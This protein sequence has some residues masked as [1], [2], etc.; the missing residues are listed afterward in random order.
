M[1]QEKSGKTQFGKISYEYA[2]GALKASRFAPLGEDGFARIKGAG[3]S[4]AV[5][6]ISE[7]GYPP[8]AEGFSPADSIDKLTEQL[9]DFIKAH[10]PD[11]VLTGAL[12]FE[13][14]A[15]NLKIYLK[16]ARSSQNT[17]G[18]GAE[19]SGFSL[20]SGAFDKE[21][22]KI[23]GESGDFSLLGKDLETALS[24]AAEI[25][26]PSFLSCKID[27]AFFSR[28][29][30]VAKKA[31]ETSLQKLLISYGA[32]R[33]SLTSLRLN[34]LGRDEK[35]HFYAFFPISG[36]SN[37]DEDSYESSES[38]VSAKSDGYDKIIAKYGKEFE[39]ALDELDFDGQI[40]FIARFFFLKKAETT[41]LRLI[42]AEK[43]A[44]EKERGVE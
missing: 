12:F 25:E 19:D 7:Y 10:S 35:E 27:N 5:K 8:A 38:K 18:G 39:K 37:I 34:Q 41:R 15:R 2:V 22:L 31:R 9:I 14:D 4:T 29:V 26:D 44:A 3:Y 36:E 17:F 13:E 11:P 28:S 1:T 43:A 6:L 40:G 33:N 16:A 21:I 24:G 30:S 23:C 32:L 20:P 42:F